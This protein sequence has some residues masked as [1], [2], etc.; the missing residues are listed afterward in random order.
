MFRYEITTSTGVRG[1]VWKDWIEE[2]PADAPADAPDAP[3]PP[4]T[5]SNDE[6]APAPLGTKATE[7][8]S[9]DG[10]PGKKATEPES[11]DNAPGTK[12]TEPESG[13]DVLAPPGTKAT[14][15]EPGDDAEP[16]V[17]RGTKRKSSQ[18]QSTWHTWHVTKGSVLPWQPA[19]SN[20]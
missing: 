4:G 14:E 9:G 13:D 6:P 3:V 19:E 10:A 7:P 20:V 18:A 15:P 8:E 12:A 16:D 11:G 17:A 2:I 1:Y 5:K